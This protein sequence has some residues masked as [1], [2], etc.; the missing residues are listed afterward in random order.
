MNHRQLEVVVTTILVLFL[1]LVSAASH[2]ATVQVTVND[3]FFSPSTL[4]INAGDTVIWVWLGFDQHDTTSVD[5]LWHSPLQTR[6]AT[7]SHT[8]N[9]AGSF[10]YFCTPHRAIGMVGTIVVQGAANQPPTVSLTS[11]A[12]NQTFS[13]SDTITFSANASDDQGVAKVEFFADGN[14]I[15]SADTTAPYSVS[16]SL[17]AGA[18]AITAKATD[19]GG[20]STS[21]AGVTITVNALTDQPPTVSLTSPSNG[22][23]FQATDTITFT[24]NA[25][26]DHGIT[27]VDYLEGRILLGSATTPPYTVQKTLSAGTHVLFARA[28]DTANQPGI[29]QSVTVTV[30]AATQ[31]QPPTITLTSPQSAAILAA[32]ATVKLSATATD[33][34]GV[35]QVEFFQ[36]GVS[37]GSDTS[38]PYETT[39]QNL[40]PGVYNFSA[41]ARDNGG[42]ATASTPVQI[43]VA[44]APQITS[45]TQNGASFTVT[46][47]ATDGISLD[48]QA[49]TD[50]V[51]WTTVATATAANSAVTLTDTSSGPMRFYRIVA[52]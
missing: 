44:A 32:P 48:L 20:L 28:F 49:T 4:T 47:N 12:N 13:T 8:F 18:H 6:G 50:F 19:T 35:T 17:P 52:H 23:T 9:T 33:D 21:T 1:N 11:P 39:V 3:D 37:L 51:N 24:A 43:H 40:A 29:S 30:N 45:F 22:A 16:A 5:G 36:D 41:V 7:F 10:D 46:A 38:A 26:D 27:R 15:S 42:L 14:L 2:A 31:N 34:S 25:N